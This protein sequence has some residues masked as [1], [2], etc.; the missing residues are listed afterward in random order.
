MRDLLQVRRDAMHIFMDSASTINLSAHHPSVCIQLF[1]LISSFLVDPFE[2]VGPFAVATMKGPNTSSVPPPPALA[3]MA[4]E[5]FTKVAQ[6][7]QNR[8]Q[9]AKHVSQEDRWRLFEALLHR[10]PVSDRD[11]KLVMAESWFGYIDKLIFALY[12]LVFMAPPAVKHKIRRKTSL[13]FGPILLRMIKR[14]ALQFPPEYRQIYVYSARR[15]IETLKLVDEGKDSFETPE[16]S[17]PSVAFGMGYGEEG[18]NLD[19]LGNG[20]LGGYQ[21]EITWGVMRSAIMD[22]VTFNEM[23]SLARLA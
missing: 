23:E 6:P 2:A 17:M 12:C 4:L 7:D 10:L 20:M 5:L 21:D 18:H 8:L 9:L 3:E 14:F 11:Y 19:E 22:G 15:A 16:N 1:E 13:G